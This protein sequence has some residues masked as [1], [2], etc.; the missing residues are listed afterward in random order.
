MKKYIFAAVFVLLALF[1]IFTDNDRAEAQTEI[2]HV[3][4]TTVAAETTPP[5]LTTVTAATSVPES[6]T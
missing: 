6:L 3:T 1:V 5:Q 4:A 2:P